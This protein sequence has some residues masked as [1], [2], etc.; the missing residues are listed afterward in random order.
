M[1]AEELKWYQRS[2]DQFN[3]EMDNNTSVCLQ[4]GDIGKYIIGLNQH[5]G[6]IE[7]QDDLKNT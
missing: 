5:D 3:M 2:N 1:H 4:M 7:G 6:R